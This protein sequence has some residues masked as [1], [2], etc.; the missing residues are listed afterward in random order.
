MLFR[1]LD[2]IDRWESAVVTVQRE[3]AERLLARPGTKAYGVPTVFFERLT[4]RERLFNITPDRFKPRPDVVSTALRILRREQPLFEVGDEAWFRRTVK[5][6]FGQ[7]RKTILNNLSS[8]VLLDRER[9]V[10]VLARCGIDPRVRAENLSPQAFRQLAEALA[11][12]SSQ[13]V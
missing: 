5:A 11:G 12:Q 7:R 9:L 10:E 13:S 2:L 4:R 1:L 3:F 8:L 6:C